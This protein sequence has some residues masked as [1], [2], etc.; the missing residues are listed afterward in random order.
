MVRQ[1]QYIETV[2]VSTFLKPHTFRPLLCNLNCLITE[3]DNM[4][5]T[6]QPERQS[7][8]KAIANFVFYGISNFSY[9]AKLSDFKIDKE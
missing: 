6:H 1:V 4:Y 8:C 5:N 2:I 9:V 7:Y 3:I